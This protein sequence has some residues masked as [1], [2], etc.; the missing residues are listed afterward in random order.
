M[1]KIKICHLTSAHSR[2][3]TRIFY[4]ECVSLAKIKYYDVSL[5]VADGRQY[6]VINSV[7]IHGVDKPTGRL[8][9]FFITP[10]IIYNKAINI[11]ADI[12]HFHDPELIPI[13]IMLL[14][15]RWQKVQLLSKKQD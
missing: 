15:L 4:K 11:N 7:K 1:D 9:R 6:E 3:D 10:R 13:G 5:V 2:N 8:Y 12:Y 14:R